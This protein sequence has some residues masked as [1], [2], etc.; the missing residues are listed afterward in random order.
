M[1]SFQDINPL[2]E[3]LLAIQNQ[4]RT[5]ALVPT[6]GAL[7]KGHESLIKHAKDLADDV[8]VSIFLNP[9]QFAPHEDFQTYPR[10]IQTDHDICE[11]LGVNALFM[12]SEAIIYPPNG[13]LTQVSVPSLSH[14][15]CG[16][17][18]PQFFSGVT[19]VV[20]RLLNIVC[21]DHAIFGEKDYQQFVIIKTCVQNL[22]LPIHIHCSSIIRDSHGLALS[23]RNHY[24]SD[25]EKQQASSIYKSLCLAKEA[26]SEGMVHPSALDTLIQ[27]S[28]DPSITLDYIAYVDTDTL[29]PAQDVKP[30]HRILFAGVLNK[31]RLIDTIHL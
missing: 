17:S 8:V 13:L 14:L 29:L 25:H 19:N 10:S 9:I 21:P 3:Y 12:P 20:I 22:F 1:R 5:I 11:S 26:V 18:R 4:N 24:L 15:Y 31:T 2:R 16:Q 6:M 7:H 23:S 27:E 30:G 28:L